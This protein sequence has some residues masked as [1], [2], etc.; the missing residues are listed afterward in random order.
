MLHRDTLHCEVHEG[1]GPF[2]LLVHGMLA[3]RAQWQLNL[4]ALQR[5]SRPVVIELWG[6]ARSPA[7]AD[8]QAYRPGAYLAEFERIRRELGAQQ[9]LV[10]GQS[11]GAALT[12]RYALEHPQRVRAQIFTNSNS[13][14]ASPARMEARRPGLEA[15]AERIAREGRPALA[16]MGVHPRHARH[17]PADVQAALL[18]DCELHDPAGIALTSLH[19]VPH[20]SVREQVKANRVPAL[21]VF[22]SLERRFAEAAAF[23]RESM[24]ELE[25]VSAPAGHA[26]NI[27]AADAFNRAAAD[28][29]RARAR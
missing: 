27:G 10:C 4:A 25:V 24:P 21:L 19:T 6:H 3:S 13:A 28:F 18:A 17:L 20:S 5:V 29:I 14:L 11:L 9:W 16:E 15:L 8:A 7:P 22:G 23:A 26:V 2:L 1:D 12:L